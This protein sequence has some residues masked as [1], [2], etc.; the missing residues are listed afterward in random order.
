MTTDLAVAEKG[1]SRMWDAAQKMD[2][3]THFDVERQLRKVMQGCVIYLDKFITGS[4]CWPFQPEH[5]VDL[6]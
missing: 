3:G 4:K 1:P 5:K 2:A 6:G